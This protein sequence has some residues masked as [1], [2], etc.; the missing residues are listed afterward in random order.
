M[1]QDHALSEELRVRF[2]IAVYLD[3]DLTGLPQQNYEAQLCR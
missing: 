3:S 2:L 1:Q